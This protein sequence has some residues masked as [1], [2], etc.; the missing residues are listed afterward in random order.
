MEKSENDKT[1]ILIADDHP[2]VRKGLAQAIGKDSFFSIV[3]ECGD[4][5]ETLQKILELKPDIALLDISMPGMDGLDIIRNI[6][7]E[8]NTIEFVILTMYDNEE[9]FNEAMDIGVK[10]YLL[11]DT[12]IG[13]VMKCL[14]TVADGR[15]YIC[16]AIS[17]YLV[18]YKSRNDDLAQANPSL[19]DLTETERK[20][21]NLISENKTSKEIAAELFISARTVQNHRYNICA[22]L[23]LHGSNKLLQFAL[24][25]K[26][27]LSSD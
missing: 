3:A 7:K 17:D 10:G 11:K 21:L 25:N 4:G 24:E 12:A 26:D 19:S 16:P 2:V 13:E 20:I 9:Y 23:N 5:D 1:T 22:K 14:H 6:R 27:I 8:N 15:H 18:S